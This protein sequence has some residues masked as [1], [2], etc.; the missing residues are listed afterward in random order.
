MASASNIGNTVLL[1]GGRVVNADEEFVADVLVQND[2][3]VQVAPN[4]KAPA[5]DANVRIID[6]TGKLIIP[7]GID[8]HTHCELPFMGQVAADDFEYGTK[9]AVAGGTTML[10]DF[11]IPNPGQ[12][13]LEVYKTWYVTNNKEKKK[14]AVCVGF[15]C[16]SGESACRCE[17]LFPGMAWYLTQCP[18]VVNS[19]P[20]PQARP[21]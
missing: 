20:S 18:C 1:R 9:A 12:N 17:Y 3:I 14:D 8:P 2:K 5:A 21:C 4:I 13:L 7:G 15:K 19:L 16:M 10:I 6:C 11:A